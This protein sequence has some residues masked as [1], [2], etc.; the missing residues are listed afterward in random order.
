MKK[1]PKVIVDY[2]LAHQ[3]LWRALGG[4]GMAVRKSV[5]DVLFSALLLQHLLVP[6][7][8][9]QACCETIGRMLAECNWSESSFFESQEWFDILGIIVKTSEQSGLHSRMQIDQVVMISS[10]MVVIQLP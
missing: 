4:S 5:V 1:S 9:S 6:G 2:H 8:H 3:L 10:T 7:G